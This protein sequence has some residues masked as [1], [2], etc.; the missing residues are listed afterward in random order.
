MAD[1]FEYYRN[2]KLSAMPKSDWTRLFVTTQ[3]R[4]TAELANKL[5]KAVPSQLLATKA[6]TLYAPSGGFVLYLKEGNGLTPQNYRKVLEGLMTSADVVSVL[7]AFLPTSNEAD[8]IFMTGKLVVHLSSATKEAAKARAKTLDLVVSEDLPMGKDAMLVL[9]AKAGS[10]IFALARSF[11]QMGGARIVEPNI[12][13]QAQS[14]AVPN[15]PLYSTQWFLEQSSDKDIDASRA[16][17]YRA[18][19][20]SQATVAVIDGNGYD[21]S[22]P[23]LAG[24]IVSAY[25]AVNQDNDPSPENSSANHGTPCA[26]LIAAVT[27]NS[28]GVAGVGSTYQK[29]APCVLGYNASGGNFST[30]ATVIGRVASWIVGVANVVAS[31]HSYGFGSASFATSVEAS[32]NTMRNNPRGGLGAVL[33][34]STGNDNLL[35]PTQYPASYGVAVGVGASTEVDAR[36]SFSNYGNLCD[37]A[38]PGTNTRST[39]RQGSAGYDAT[40]YTYFNGTSAACP[41]A[42]GVAGLVGGC[43]LSLT[44]AQIEDYLLRSCEK[45]GGYS[46]S[47]ISG[48]PYTWSNE[49]GYGRINAEKAVGLAL[50]YGLM[51]TAVYT[52]NCGDVYNGDLTGFANDVNNYFGVSWNETGPDQTFQFT[53]TSRTRVDLQ[54]TNLAQDL[55]IFVATDLNNSGSTIAYGNNGIT[56]IFEAGTYYVNVD[57]YNG[58]TGAFT[59]TMNCVCIPVTSCSSGDYISNFTLNGTS[60]TAN[61]SCPD[62]A[63]TYN[64]TPSFGLYFGQVNNITVNH[65]AWAETDRVWIDLNRDNDFDDAGEL[66][67]T[68][69]ARAINN[70]GTFQ[71]PANSPYAPV[72]G[73]ITTRMRIECTYSSFP[74]GGACTN[75]TYG[76]VED[77]PV[78]LYSSYSIPDAG[79][80]YCPGTTGSLSFTVSATTP[81]TANYTAYY[82]NGILAPVQV[83]TGTGSPM[84]ISVPANTDTTAITTFYIYVSSDYNTTQYGQYI[85]TKG[86]P[87]VVLRSGGQRCG[88]GTVQLYSQGAPNQPGG[89]YRYWDAISGGTLQGTTTNRVWTTPTITGTKSFYVE[90]ISGDGCSSSRLGSVATVSPGPTIIGIAGAGLTY[91]GEPFTVVGNNLSGVTNVL[92]NGVSAGTPSSFSGT[93]L[94]SRIPAGATSG[95]VTVVKPGCPNGTFSSLTVLTDGTSS[96][97]WRWVRRAYSAGADKLVRVRTTVSG[98]SYEVGSFSGSVTLDGSGAPGGL[99]TLTSAGGLDGLLTR[100]RKDGRLEWAVQFSGAGADEALGLATDKFNYAYVS[101]YFSGSMTITAASGTPVT[102]TSAGGTDMF[103]AKIHPNGYVVYA[104]RMGASGND[105]AEGIDVAPDLRFYVAGS[106]VGTTAIGGISGTVIPLTSRGNSDAFLAKF[107]DIGTLYWAIQAGGTGNDFGYGAAA[108]ITGGGY[109]MGSYEGTA[110]FNSSLAGTTPISK[111]VV[112]GSDGFVLGVSITGQLNWVA[113]MG[114]TT[115]ENVRDVAPDPRGTGIVAVGG[116]SN[117]ATFGSLGSLTATGFYDAFAVRLSNAGA[118]EWVQK[119]G[120]F[121]QDQ[122]WGVRLD[123]TGAPAV[124]MSFSQT[125]NLFSSAATNK[126]YSYGGTDAAVVVLSPTGAA[127]TPEHVTGTVGDDFAY[128]VDTAAAGG[129]ANGFVAAG[130]L[131]GGTQ[132]RLLGP[133]VSAGSTD[134]W[135]AR[136]STSAAAVAREILNEDRP[137]DVDASGL[138]AWPN[139]ASQSVGGF[140]LKLNTDKSWTG[141][142]TIRIYGAD[143][144]VAYTREV[145]AGFLMQG[146][147]LQAAL[148]NG[149]YTVRVDADKP[150][151]ARIVIQ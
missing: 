131:S 66:V 78:T 32:Y 106:F 140:N 64:T 115:N 86:Q 101:G 92:V 87:N 38:A 110:T 144:R 44:A 128:S 70:T 77:Y 93:E 4:P 1:N 148:P 109:L 76:E 53:L 14:H 85:T 30:D 62:F 90:Y 81:P 15:D 20:G 2:G 100:H 59:L 91:P 141:I 79:Q 117:S 37:I 132:F 125:A 69:A 10:D 50:G 51:G 34:A 151:H 33:C 17:D 41:V 103:V 56:Q 102:L 9:Q 114:G 58:A 147:A 16:W 57:G 74:A 97:N 108:D 48:R 80:V 149:A 137:V 73:S 126:M 113:S 75:R 112:G 13:F 5:Q 107:T 84:T 24:N 89:F 99:Q 138:V 118:F 60:T 21:M 22:H 67:Y 61:T 88:P 129:F 23:D 136:N 43:N 46:Y 143:G 68:S 25:D 96:K 121:G 104:F 82:T 139:P 6:P 35:N 146:L 8:P 119:A 150:Y 18:L 31:S 116:F 29:V 145:Q 135:V 11:Y 105:R 71:I 133:Y 134:G 47:T 52:L 55:D 28:V 49:L 95:V 40:E 127:G 26:G 12:V 45:V 27:N 120:G 94:L 142:A 72:A 124:A 122:A 130:A 63:Y 7:P 123:R 98:H 3:T 36:A 42:A 111:T 83:G 39:D 54:L 65:G 19:N